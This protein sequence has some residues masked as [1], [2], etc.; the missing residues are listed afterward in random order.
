MSLGDLA[1]RRQALQQ[2]AQ[3]Q[4]VALARDVGALGQRVEPLRRMA[5]LVSTAWVAWRLWRRLHARR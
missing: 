5:R 2:Q 3:A 4:R 1:R